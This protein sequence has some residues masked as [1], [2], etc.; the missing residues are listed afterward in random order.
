MQNKKFALV[1]V[2]NRKNLRYLAQGLRKLN[3]EIVSTRGTAEFLRK[4][5]IEVVD[6]ESVTK[7]PPIAGKQGIKII[8]PA[9]FSGVLADRKNQD[10][11][12]DLK[13]FGLKAF[14]VIACN[15]YPF[16]KT[17]AKKKFEHK[18]AIRNLDIGG[19]A[20]VRCAA[21]N[22]EN[23]VILTDPD[24]YKMVLNKIRDAGEV[25]LPTRKKL[26]LKAFKYTASHD[27]A[28]IKYLSNLFKINK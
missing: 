16:E 27:Q 13:N 2:S 17:V 5:K 20:V 18:D 1:S 10:H 21:K 3:Y 23:V 19:P 4:H 28:I 9:I 22:Y 14:D 7:Y 24:D 26:S 11:M 6:V 12:N 8:H 25:D 15:F